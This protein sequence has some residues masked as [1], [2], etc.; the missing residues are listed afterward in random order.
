MSAPTDTEKLLQLFQEAEERIAQEKERAKRAET[1]LE[2]G[3][4]RTEKSR[5]TTLDEYLE[6]CHKLVYARLAVE[7]DPSRTT[8]GTI[9][10]YN[11]LVPGHLK[12][13]TSFFDDQ[14]EMLSIIYSY[15]AVEERLFDNR[16]YLMTLGNKVSAA[17]IANEKMLENFLHNVVEE[18]VMCIIHELSKSE[19]FQQ[20]LNIG[21]GIKFENHLKAINDI[22]YEVVERE[23]RQPLPP[24]HQESEEESGAEP[25]R[26]KTPD[27][28]LDPAKLNAD[29]IY[30]YRYEE[31]GLEKRSSFHTFAWAC[32]TW[33]QDIVCKNKIPKEEEARFQHTAEE[34]TAAA[35]TQTYHY[36][37]KSGL[38]YSLLTTGEAIVFLKIDWRAPEVLYYHLAEPS[39]EVEVHSQFRSCTA[40]AQYLAFHLLA[41]RDHA[42]IA[43]D[44]RQEVIGRLK[45]WKVDFRRMAS[46]MPVDQRQAPPTSPAWTP[47]TYRNVDRTVRRRRRE[48]NKNTEPGGKL[49][50][51][52][53]RDDDSD[54]DGGFNPA[55]SPS[56]A[57]RR[58]PGQN[59]GI[60]RSQWVAQ[61]A[62]GETS[63]GGSKN[64][65]NES[66]PV[67]AQYCTQRCLLG[68]VKGYILDINCPNYALHI[69]RNSKKNSKRHHITHADFLEQL[70]RQ[71]KR[72]LDSEITSLDLTGARGALFKVSLLEY[73]Y[74]F[75][76]KGTVKVFIPDLKH[77]ALVYKRLEGIQGTH[78]PVFLGAIDLN[79]LGR[80]YYYD[81]RV[82]VVHL[83][84]MSWG[85]VGVR[86]VD[87]I[88]LNEASLT[89]MAIRS[90]KAVH[91]EGVIHMDARR[92]NML[93]NAETQGVMIID[94]ERSQLLSPPRRHLSA[95][96]PNKRQRIQEKGGEIKA[97]PRSSGVKSELKLGFHNDIQGVRG[98]F[99]QQ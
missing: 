70:S 98:A 53:R 12:Q 4:N 46:T 7:T 96:E 76:G 86:D 79:A 77:E 9:R 40:V 60:R 38:T 78:V 37:V 82:D 25:Q 1:E 10:A 29:Q 5:S 27:P 58:Q 72:T 44:R 30:V 41:L 2:Q 32:T 14:N 22:A 74:T 17:P 67:G 75:I 59:Q 52:R 6:A 89:E 24:P 19:D 33:T 69:P 8:A 62:V 39:P 99:M 84:F 92:D 71:L 51:R 28:I 15:F 65:S 42:P 45:Q 57:E 91:Q 56:P 87:A 36:M 88:G 81:V 50:V 43:Q 93:F 47:T 11:K 68:L 55:H 21:A 3:K 20:Q 34:L 48:T 97:V 13:W 80:T 90:M 85:G 83:T 18:P 23:R 94:F 73:G 16:T 31:A 26:P 35:I 64:R 54:N 95:L 63:Q 66:N 49:P 61:Q